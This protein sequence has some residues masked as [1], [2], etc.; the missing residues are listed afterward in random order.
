MSSRLTR[1]VVTGGDGQLAQALRPYFPYAEFPSKREL[2][3][4]NPQ[5]CRAYFSHRS[6]DVV[7][8]AGA[9]T[10][11]RAAPESYLANNILGT[12]H[13]AR[14]CRTKRA[15]LVY[16]STDAVY[17]GPGPHRED[18]PVGPASAYARSKL[19]G[20]LAAQ[21][22]DDHCVVRGSWYSGLA[23]TSA[24]TDAYTSRIPVGKA[25]ALV[26]ALAVSSATGIVNVGGPRRSNYEVAVTEFNPR[27]QP[28]NRLQ[29]PLPVPADL[30]LDLTRMR[31]LT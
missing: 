29:L 9:E 5:S 4:A 18:E 20:E 23:W 13:V 30:S 21:L 10:D 19:A 17:H 27:V 14:W 6:V 31:G 28:V 2:D 26:A 7:V 15:R 1:I 16:L 25:A 12:T 3:V 11:P 22:V 8:H 24:A